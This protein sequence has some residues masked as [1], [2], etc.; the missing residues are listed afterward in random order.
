MMN[1]KKA[2]KYRIYPNKKQRIQLHKTFGCCR[3]VYN[4]Y[5]ALRKSEYELNNRMMSYVDCAK[6]LTQLKK[7]DD[8][9]WLR[10]VD[11]T[12]LQSSLKNLDLAFKNFF[13]DEKV[14]YPH[15]K[16][17]KTHR[18]SYTTKKVNSNIEYHHRYIK[19]PKLG[20]IRTRNKLIPEGDIINATVTCTPSGRYYV[21]IL[22][23]NVKIPAYE[24]TNQNIGIDVGIKDFCIFSN[25]TKIR[26]PHY[27]DKSLRKLVK[28]QRQ[29]SRKT[30][31][32]SNWNNT[33]IKVAKM[34]EHIMNQRRDY[35]NKLSTQ[36]VRDYDVIMMESLDIRNLQTNK[37]KRLSRQI[38]DVSWYEFMRQIEY[39]SMWY[40]KQM[41]S[42][43]QYYPSS[44]ICTKCGYQNPQ[45]KNLSI[46]KWRC[47]VCGTEH[48]RDIN[49]AVNIL[50]EGSRI[51]A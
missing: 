7:T 22:C 47:P 3:F 40:G 42:I 10:E 49:A 5:L 25:G 20:M 35:L 51:L 29:L 16:S 19:L 6:D 39:K 43:G 50:T 30:R 32:S 28:L 4:H 12:A 48:D 17:R 9:S 15:F 46:R 14:G 34:N 38:A 2:Y 45:M 11:S 31:G 41:I 37:D 26:N 8:Y 21:S 36:I 1:I 24:K 44:Q 33:R 18:F 13:R 27:L 23:Q